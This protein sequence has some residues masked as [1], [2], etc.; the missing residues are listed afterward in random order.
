M[1]CIK[2]E[3]SSLLPKIINAAF[4]SAPMAIAPCYASVFAGGLHTITPFSLII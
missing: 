1:L 3:S 2:H 4:T